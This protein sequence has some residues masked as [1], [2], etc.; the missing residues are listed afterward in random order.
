MGSVPR[1]RTMTRSSAVAPTG[2][3]P[4]STRSGVTSSSVAMPVPDR[5]TTMGSHMGH[6]T[7]TRTCAAAAPSRCGL[8][9]S[10]TRRSSPGC[11]AKDRPSSLELNWSASA[12]SKDTRTGVSTFVGL[13]TTSSRIST[14]PSSTLPKSSAR[15]GT[16]TKAFTPCPS[17][18]SFATPSRPTLSA[19]VSTSSMPATAPS[20]SAVKRTSTSCSPP[21]FSSKASKGTTSMLGR[22]AVAPCTRK[23]ARPRLD[24]RTFIVLETPTAER[25]KSSV[26][27]VAASPER[28]WCDVGRSHPTPTRAIMHTATHT[29]RNPTIA[30]STRL[31]I[32]N[33]PRTH[34]PHLG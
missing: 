9:D 32:A 5:F 8:K 14:W 23:G 24:R 6:S 31:V 27:G 20:T 25:P 4:K 18:P 21:A 19:S 15:P 33:H 22:F 26:S 30:A 1:L 13:R 16:S 28:A 7:P 10:G 12:P 3:R 29:Q 17:R 11:S 34:Q 2:T